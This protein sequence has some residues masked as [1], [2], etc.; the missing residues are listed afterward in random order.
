VPSELRASAVGWYAATVGLTG[1]VASLVGGALWTH[2][3][4]AAT[5]LFGAAAALIG[6]LALAVSVAPKAAA[7]PR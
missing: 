6:G 3:S 2:V 5:F 7:E 1:L 4:P